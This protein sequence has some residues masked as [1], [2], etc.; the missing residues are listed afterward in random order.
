MQ[1]GRLRLYA[2]GVNPNDLRTWATVAGA[3]ALAALP[4]VRQATTY[5]CGPA[6]LAAALA[7][8]GRTATEPALAAKLGTTPDD[9]T[10]IADMVRVARSYGIDAQPREGLTLADLEAAIGAGEVVIVVLQAWAKPEPPTGGYAGKWNEGHYVIP[11]AIDREAILFEDP[12][13]EGARAYLTIAEFMDRW[14]AFDGGS[15]GKVLRAGIVLHGDATAIAP[16]PPALG[17][18]VAMR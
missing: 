11:V 18:P 6:T 12:A 17:A 9:G 3:G 5:T 16:H 4:D 1:R 15:G 8:Y 13:V 7:W 14:H 2:C 10:T